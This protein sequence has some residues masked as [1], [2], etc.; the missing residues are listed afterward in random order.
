M[1]PLQQWMLLILLSVSKLV[2]RWDRW[3]DS[4]SSINSY[5]GNVLLPKATSYYL[6]YL[7]VFQSLCCHSLYKAYQRHDTLYIP[8][9]WHFFNSSRGNTVWQPGFVTPSQY[10]NPTVLSNYNFTFIRENY[11]FLVVFNGPSSFNCTPRLTHSFHKVCHSSSYF[12]L[13]TQ[14]L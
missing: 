1:L 6:K 7:C 10:V 11:F 8:R 9:S 3:T 13:Q 5:W 4:L 12:L 2:E 14:L